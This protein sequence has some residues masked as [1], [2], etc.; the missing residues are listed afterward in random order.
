MWSNES[1]FYHIYPIG[2]CDAPEWNDFQSESRNRIS[3][4][5]DWVPQM[6]KLGANALYLGPIFESTK[7]GYD[8][9]DYFKIDC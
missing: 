4:I 7:H 1:I 5:V 9:A 8:T 2:F 3:K 6:Q